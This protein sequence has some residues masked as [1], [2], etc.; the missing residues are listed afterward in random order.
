[1]FTLADVY[2]VT[3]LL[4][5]L[6]ISFPALVVVTILCLPAV[7]ERATIRL[8][9][10]PVKCFFGGLAVFATLTLIIIV[11]ANVPWGPVRALSFMTALAGMSLGVLGSAGVVRL[12]EERLNQWS[13]P[14][15]KLTNLLRAVFFYQFAAFMPLIGWFVFFPFMLAMTLGA[16]VFALLRW[17]PRPVLPEGPTAELKVLS[18][19]P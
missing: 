10:T 3:L 19:R 12:L 7:T 8:T 17:M 16:A 6:F 9:Q 1:M 15:S 2:T 18:E 5:S 11:T 4:I 14:T 13:A